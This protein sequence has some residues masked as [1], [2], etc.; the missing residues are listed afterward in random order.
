MC[1]RSSKAFF[2]RIALIGALSLPTVASGS[3]IDME[4]IAPVGGQT[5]E[6]STIRTFGA[7]QLALPHGHYVDSASTDHPPSN[8]SDWLLFD[9]VNGTHDEPFVIRKFAGM[10]FS[11]TSFDATTWDGGATTITAVG[12]LSGGGSVTQSF[13]TDAI[14]A[15]FETFFFN[16]NFTDLVS[17][18]F[19]DSHPDR[20]YGQAAFDNIVLDR[21][22]PKVPVPA[23]LALWSLGLFGIGYQRLKQN[24][25]S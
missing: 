21:P 17:L 10:A 12:T 13:T 9:S 19:V 1:S 15:A 23:P 11:A 7:F 5:L 18:S 16:P 6:N 20:D 3:I 24:R 8:G 2:S 22:L 4:G 25:A 14:Q